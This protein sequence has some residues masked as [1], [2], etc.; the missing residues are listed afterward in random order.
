M[1]QGRQRLRSRNGGFTLIE[2]MV[3]AVVLA[4]GLLGVGA[5]AVAGL[6]DGGETRERTAAALL[7]AELGARLRM[8]VSQTSACATPCPLPGGLPEDW[9]E[10]VAADLPG[11]AAV[12]CR[13]A[14]PEDGS[15]EDAACDGTGPAVIKLLWRGRERPERLVWRA[16]P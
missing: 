8:S 3:A 11:G 12:L 14:T 13:D 5:L 7:A 16:S 6:R 4:V 15:P 1:R 9:R 10:R 2:V